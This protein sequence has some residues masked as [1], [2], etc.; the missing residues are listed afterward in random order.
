MAPEPS[1]LWP[2]TKELTLDPAPAHPVR[3]RPRELLALRKHGGPKDR[4]GLPHRIRGR[5]PGLGPLLPG[6]DPSPQLRPPLLALGAQPGSPF[7]AVPGA[8]PTLPLTPGP[9]PPGGPRPA[10][11]LTEG[12]LQLLAAPHVSHEAPLE[13]AH[14]GVELR[15]WR[16][17]SGGSGEVPPPTPAAAAS[18]QRA[19]CTVTL[20]AGGRQTGPTRQGTAGPGGLAAPGQAAAASLRSGLPGSRRLWPR[21]RV[22][23]GLG[24]RGWLSAS[25]VLPT[26]SATHVSELHEAPLAQLAHAG[27]GGSRGQEELHQ[28]HLLAPE[29]GAHGPGGRTGRAAQPGPGH[30]GRS[31]H[32]SSHHPTGPAPRPPDG[33]GN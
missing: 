28:R 30:S 14:G 19:L 21:P 4:L 13:G 5:C 22:P 3:L 33:W 2:S 32:L 20:R 24:H 25:A 6:A 12:L 27:V 7:P 17:Q 15:L 16:S 10:G 18:P 11:P 23:A 26:P 31:V 29:H 8:T 9:P 1:A